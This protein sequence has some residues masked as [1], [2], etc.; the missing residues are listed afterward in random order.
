MRA[1]T[2]ESYAAARRS[3]ARRARW[4]EAG[5]T[6]SAE[7]LEGVPLFRDFSRAHFEAL[8]KVLKRETHPA[9]HVLFRAGDLA[10]QFL[11]LMR[12]EVALREEPNELFRL[13]AV[14]TIGELGAMTG[15]ARNTDA[16]TATEV[17][18]WSIP[19]A[20]LLKFFEA[21]GEV[22]YPFYRNLLAAAS[23]KIRQDRRRLTDMRANVIR[24]QKRMKDLRELVLAARETEISKPV[25]EALDESI[26]N[27]RRSH[28]RV[29]PAPALP[30][31][32]RMDDGVTVRLLELSE[33]YLK[34]ELLASAWPKGA[35]WTGVLIL[36]SG[37]IMVS[38]RVIRAGNDGVV[39]QLDLLIAD[40]KA[41]MLDYITRL[42]MLDF[43]I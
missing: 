39:M 38:G 23:D 7:G 10:T 33:G 20:D 28:Y 29:T 30:A 6:I 3:A 25:F 13:R 5:M 31:S 34:L 14:S 26:E 40:Y 37:E 36:P 1:R 9:G 4:Y 41:A 2:R 8:A 43:V 17:E 24:T 22:A 15:L 27:N 12:G 32:V 18:I 19:V 11:V 21:H 16:I 35:E 42:Q